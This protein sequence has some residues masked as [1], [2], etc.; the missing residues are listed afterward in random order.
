MHNPS[1]PLTD[2]QLRELI[3]DCGEKLVCYR[4]AHGGNYVGGKEYTTL[5]ERIE[6][7]LAT[8]SPDAAP[9]A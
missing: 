8:T 3:K 7:Y 2:A 4:V 6:K 5:M 9:E 1:A